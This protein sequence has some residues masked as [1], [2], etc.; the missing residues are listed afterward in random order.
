MDYIW[1]VEINAFCFLIM[2][3]LLYS[4]CKN[5]DRQTKQRYYMKSVV[6]GMISLICDI[7]WALLGLGKIPADGNVNFCING[8]YE[9][10]TVL[11]GYYWLCYVEAAL[12][13]KFVKSRY[14][15]Y[16]AKFPVFFITAGVIVSYFN[17]FL[18]YVDENGVYQRGEYILIHVFFC[19][20]YTVIT[21][22]HAFIKALKCKS[23]LKAKEYKVLSMFLLFPL[24][25]GI[26]Q[27][28]VPDIPSISVG[29]T[30]AFLFV[31]ID[32]QNLLISVDT[33]SGLN[34]RNQLLRYLTSHIKTDTEEKKLYLFMLNVNKFKSIN[35]TYGHVEGDAALIRCAEA[36]KAAANDGNFIGRYGGDEFII[37]AELKD[38]YEAEEF[39]RIICKKLD[40]ICRKDRVPY[41]LSFSCGYVSYSKEMDSIQ[42]FIDAADRKL[43][44]AK[45]KLVKR[46][47]RA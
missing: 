42:S 41:D 37:I 5:Y 17:G 27:I 34:N 39:C 11:M 38:D 19:H 35:D 43:Y 1:I 25:I 23:T 2:G 14:L 31:Y 21:S 28:M 9:I 13:S 8:I 20:I 40:E 4:L 10:I 46:K 15:K 47:Q 6:T 33:L 45:M 44:E 22:V 24:S 29:V 7:S 30:L 26:I 16:L 12:D 18:F 32:L 36:L 3:I